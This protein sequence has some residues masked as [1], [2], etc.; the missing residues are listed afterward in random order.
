MGV[1]RLQV[2]PTAGALGAR[3]L[4][5]HPP[6]IP[7][8]PGCLGLCSSLARSLENY[9]LSQTN[10]FKSW[11]KF[12]PQ[13]GGG[14]GVRICPL[15]PTKDFPKCISRQWQICFLVQKKNSRSPPV[16]LGSPSWLHLNKG[17]YYKS[18][19]N[20]SF[21]FILPRCSEETKVSREK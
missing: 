10:Q 6:P 16:S 12:R 3:E 15:S 1:V 7:A 17:F 9:F 8:I 21:L 18:K 5:Q 2:E 20:I 14:G 13:G 4:S 11:C 19:M